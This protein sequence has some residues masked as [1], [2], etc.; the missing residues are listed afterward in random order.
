MA[1]WSSN[2]FRCV[3]FIPLLGMR[4]AHVMVRP[5]G[6]RQEGDLFSLCLVTGF[7]LRATAGGSRTV[8]CKVG[9]CPG[10]FE[11]VGF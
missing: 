8:V 6:A 5:Q 4:E 3:F 9:R 11:K 10:S 7:F 1:R 2:H